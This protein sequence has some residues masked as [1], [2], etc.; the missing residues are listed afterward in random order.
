MDDGSRSARNRVRDACV[1]RR[2]MRL[3]PRVARLTVVVVLVVPGVTVGR[4]EV[5]VGGGRGVASM[6]LVAQVM[7]EQRRLAQEREDQQEPEDAQD[8][9][10]APGLRRPTP[11][12]RPS[13]SR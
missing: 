4:E 11:L 10:P 8:H 6:Q 3:V 7:D 9:E 13:G 5:L 1:I 2:C 12:A